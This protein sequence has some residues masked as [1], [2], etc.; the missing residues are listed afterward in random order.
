MLVKKLDKVGRLLDLSETNR[1]KSGFVVLQSGEEV[2]EHI[3]ENK[4]EAI[5]IL[6]G[7][8]KLV[9]EDEEKIVKAES[10]VYIPESAMHNVIN[11]GKKPLKYIYV[12]ALNEQSK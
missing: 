8:A 5:V 1:L 2:G 6:A 7:R 12:T 4:E 11:V 10:L 9:C 3:T